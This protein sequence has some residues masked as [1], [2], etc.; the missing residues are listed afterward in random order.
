MAGKR[1]F[2]VENTPCLRGPLPIREISKKGP[3]FLGLELPEAKKHKT[4][5]LLRLRLG[6]TFDRARFAVTGPIGNFIPSQNPE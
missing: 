5:E 4:C 2:S 6:V 3:G 1:G